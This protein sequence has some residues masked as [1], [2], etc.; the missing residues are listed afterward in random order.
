MSNRAIHFHYLLSKEFRMTHTHTHENVC[1]FS[2]VLKISI[3]SLIK[4]NSFYEYDRNGDGILSEAGECSL[5][6]Q[7]AYS[8]FTKFF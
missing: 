8:D 3:E 4:R 1:D 7:F 5:S 6:S 2:M